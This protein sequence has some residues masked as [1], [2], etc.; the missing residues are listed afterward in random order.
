MANDGLLELG[1][2]KFI[3]N[4]WNCGID[5]IDPHAY[6]GTTRVRFEQIL[7]EADSLT[8]AKILQGVLEKYPVGSEENRTDKRHRRMLDL[9][10]KCEAG[11]PIQLPEGRSDAEV[12]EV[13]LKQPSTVC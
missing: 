11:T 7:S 5:N 12:V 10:R 2:I 9:I 8:Q 13:A 4:Q 1:E 6:E 3:V